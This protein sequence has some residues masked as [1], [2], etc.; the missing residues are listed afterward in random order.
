M[1]LDDFLDEYNVSDEEAKTFNF[2][3]IRGCNGSGKTTVISQMMK[4]DTPFE[5][6]D[7]FNGKPAV[8]LTVFPNFKFACLGRYIGDRKCGGC[9]IF[10]KF[11]PQYESMMDFYS[12]TL[13]KIW[14]IGFNIIMEGVIVSTIN[15]SYAEL[16][17]KLTDKGTR[18]VYGYFITTP[19]DICI[20]RVLERN[21]GKDIN[22]KLI[23]RKRN[24]VL[25][26]AKIFSEHGVQAI[27]VDN[28][29]YPIDDTLPHFFDDVKIQLPDYKNFVQESDEW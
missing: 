25:K 28:S 27:E 26:G 2:I 9:D 13:E 4:Y 19:L 18:K 23:T 29:A 8:I 15:S 12:Q 7:T 17:K 11:Q 10:S 1:R 5:V 14:N 20:S 6:T 24:S 21:G 16:F 22:L 3:N